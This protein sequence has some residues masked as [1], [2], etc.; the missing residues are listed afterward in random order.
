MKAI[1]TNEE[2]GAHDGHEIEAYDL[3]EPIEVFSKFTDSWCEKLLQLQKWQ[4]RKE[5][6][7]I[8]LKA[9]STPKIAPAG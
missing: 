8:L 9:V 4:E 3:A 2:T 6:L 7:E 1:R 5:Q